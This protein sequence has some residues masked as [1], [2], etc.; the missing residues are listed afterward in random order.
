MQEERISLAIDTKLLD[1]LDRLVKRRGFANRSEA[2][3]E[4]IR[5][6]IAADDWETGAGQ[7][8]ATLTLVYDHTRRD[9]SDRLVEEGHSHH[10]QV[11]ATLHVHLDHDLCL[12]VH[13][14]KGKAAALR[15]LADRLGRLK[16]VL[17]SQLVIGSASH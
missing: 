12:E 16:G 15:Q 13:A 8:V 11:L 7:T 5:R 2:I 10:E 4:M 6:G 1:R 9:L 3:R 14:L 17:Q